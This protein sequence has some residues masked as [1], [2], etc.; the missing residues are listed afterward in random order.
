MGKRNACD[1]K[2]LGRAKV[3]SA[4][5]QESCSVL[6]MS[7]NDPS[8]W[9]HRAHLSITQSGLFIYLDRWKTA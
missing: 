4:L 7:S 5:P 3:L 6:L 8:L 9:R 1:L 2:I